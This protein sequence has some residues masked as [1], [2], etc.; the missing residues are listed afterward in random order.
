MRVTD[1]PAGT[2][3]C[4]AADRAANTS[5][6]QR[7]GTGE[8][9]TIEG[10]AVVGQDYT[11]NATGRSRTLDVD[12]TNS[13]FGPSAGAILQQVERSA[14]LYGFSGAYTLALSVAARGQRTSSKR[15]ALP[16]VTEIPPGL[17]TCTAATETTSTL[18]RQGTGEVVE[19]DGVAKVGASYSPGDTSKSLSVSVEL[20]GGFLGGTGV[21]AFRELRDWVALFAPQGSHR[22]TVNLFR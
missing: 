14:R 20:S 15:S 19:I 5:T 9:R 3:T 10:F 18:V 13:P 11:Q 21:D 7:Q 12:L 22:A 1:L 16:R 17:W 2:W 8:I 4:T 6:M